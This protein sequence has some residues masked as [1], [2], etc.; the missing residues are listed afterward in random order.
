M[1]E[2]GNFDYGRNGG[3]PRFDTDNYSSENVLTAFSFLFKILT[4]SFV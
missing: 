2:I 3:K 4:Q 1:T